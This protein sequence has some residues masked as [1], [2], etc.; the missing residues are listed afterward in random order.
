MYPWRHAIGLC[1]RGNCVPSDT[2]SPGSH[3]SSLGPVDFLVTVATELTSLLP[4]DGHRPRARSVFQTTSACA[5]WSQ[6]RTLTGLGNGRSTPIPKGQ[7]PHSR[8]DLHLCV[9]W[10]RTP[11]TCCK[12]CYDCVGIQRDTE[13]SECT[14]RVLWKEG[15]WDGSQKSFWNI[16]EEEK[17]TEITKSQICNS[18]GPTNAIT[19]RSM[20][21]WSSNTKLPRERVSHLVGKV[22]ESGQVNCMPQDSLKEPRPEAM[23][24]D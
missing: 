19:K 20:F 10:G 12:P 14:D 21:R 22:S 3:R 4:T 18:M 16:T 9:Q 5:Q 7:W 24:Q 6:L 8:K 1:Q 17:C 15:K 2:G 11:P 13:K 23:P